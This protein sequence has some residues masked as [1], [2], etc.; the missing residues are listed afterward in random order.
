MVLAITYLYV[1]E[2]NALAEIYKYLHQIFWTVKN[3]L[4]NKI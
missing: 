2:N 4:N 3:L 1:D